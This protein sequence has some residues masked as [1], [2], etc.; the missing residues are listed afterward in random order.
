MNYADIQNKYINI[1]LDKQNYKFS[2]AID[3]KKILGYDFRS[4]RGFKKLSD[5]HRIL[6]E[7][8]ICNYIN[9]HGLEAREGIRPTNIKR[10]IGNFKVTFEDKGYSYLFDNGSIG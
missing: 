7:G 9:G 6:A 10:E 2:N 5:E 1:E 4:M 3:V 8:L